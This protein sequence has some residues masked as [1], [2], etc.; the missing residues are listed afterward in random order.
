MVDPITTSAFAV[1]AA[2]LLYTLKSY[3]ERNYIEAQLE[4]ELTKAQI[5]EIL[6][7]A[8]SEQ[9]LEEIQFEL[10]S[11]DYEL[12]GQNFSEEDIDRIKEYLIDHVGLDEEK[13]NSLDEEYLLSIFSFVLSQ[14][15]G[16][17]STIDGENN[18]EQ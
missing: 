12:D 15:L 10:E 2:F 8:Q 9:A 11:G 7:D 16:T 17:K 5:K 3:I 13:I 4:S 14:N 6:E 18:D 1:N